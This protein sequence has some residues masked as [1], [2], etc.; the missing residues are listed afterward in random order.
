M[1][2]WKKLDALRAIQEL[3]VQLRSQ[4]L[5]VCMLHMDRAREFQTDVLEAWAAARDI[6]VTRAQGSDPPGNGT[7]ERA[8]GYIKARMRVLLGQPKEIGDA[9]DEIVRSWWPFVA[10]TAVAQHQAPVFNRKSPTVARFGS[11]V[12]TK[13]KGYGVGGRFDLQP[14]WLRAAYLGPARSVPGGHLVFTDEGNLWYT[15]HIRQFDDPPKETDDYE[16]DTEISAAPARRVRK[17]SGIVEL[18][19]SVGLIP[20]MRGEELD[21]RGEEAGMS[22]ISRLAVGSSS[23][24]SEKVVSDDAIFGRYEVSSESALGSEGGG[25]SGDLAAEYLKEGRFSMEDCLRV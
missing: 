14:R 4:G 6:E 8:A 12:Y 3:Y 11:K 20:G 1:K 22:A 10:E 7:A 5:P 19:G 25:R 24:S 13:R 2:S 23:S 15:T 16:A 17:R 21:G 9:D 18:A